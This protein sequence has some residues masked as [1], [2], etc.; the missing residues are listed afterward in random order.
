MRSRLKMESREVYTDINKLQCGRAGF[1]MCA[2]L[3]ACGGVRK[4]T[5]GNSVDTVEDVKGNRQIIWCF[6]P[7]GRTDGKRPALKIYVQT[8]G[9]RPEPRRYYFPAI[10]LMI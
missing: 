1:K 10:L 3:M 5:G 9:T 8:A 6:I 4:K 7:K 2:R